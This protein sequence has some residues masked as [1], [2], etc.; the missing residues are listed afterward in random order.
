[1]HND[2][3]CLL[4]AVSDAYGRPLDV[5][6]PTERLAIQWG[7]Y[8]LNLWGYEPIYDYDMYISGPYSICLA[9]D[10]HELKDNA[11]VACPES[12]DDVSS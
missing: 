7:C 2:S 8:I 11:I 5:R 12:Y 3:F 6:D 10:C 4:R 9:E 1:M